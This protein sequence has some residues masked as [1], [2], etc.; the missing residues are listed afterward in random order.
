MKII[1]VKNYEE[2]SKEAARIIVDLVN[3]KPNAVLGLATGGTPIGMYQNL[4]SA[5]QNGLVSFKNVITF[6]LDEY[7]GI[8][9]NHPQSYYFYMHEH[10]FNH[11][12][13]L[14]NSIN[15]PK[16]SGDEEVLAKRYNDLLNQ[17]TI[18]LQVLGIGSNGH[19]GFNEPGTPFEQETFVVKLA[20]KTR[21]DNQRFF[22]SL[23]EVPKTAITM[24]IKNI[25][26]ASAI[27]LLISGKAKADTV[28]RLLKG[29]I[30]SAFP[31]SVLH[32]HPNVTIIIDD[33][34]Y[35]KMI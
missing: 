35:S 25:T 6:N 9:Q 32:L 17:T 33:D 30:T 15:L 26:N 28:V 7:C 10:L 3:N 31:A 18:D 29:E 22:A 16:A 12:D 5:Y 34:A 23:N 8:E 20:E 21:L 24:G 19:I 14:P 4:I 11:I 27:L 1:V 2:M 13:I